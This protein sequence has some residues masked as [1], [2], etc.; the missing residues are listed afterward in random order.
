MAAMQSLTNRAAAPAVSVVIPLFNK[1]D[2]VGRAIRSVLNQSFTDFELIVVDDGSTDGGPEVVRAFADPRLRLIWQEN[3]GPGA[4][5]NWGIRESRAELIAFLDADDE[6]LPDF[7]SS[8]VA[9]LSKHPECVL[10]V[11]G[12]FMGAERQDWGQ[13]ARR[14]GIT[15]GPWRLP[16]QLRREEMKD[17]IGYFNSWAIVCRRWALDRYRG[18]YENRCTFGEDTYLWVQIALNHPVYRSLMPLVWYHS[19][20]S[21]LWLGSKNVLPAE[22]LL[23]DPAPLRDCCPPAYRPLLEDWLV[24]NAAYTVRRLNR[25]GNFEMARYIDKE[26]G[27]GERRPYTRV[28]L[29]LDLAQGHLFRLKPAAALLFGRGVRKIMRVGYRLFKT[30]PI[31]ANS[32]PGC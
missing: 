27:L 8:S 10:S 4:A 11:S 20:S 12:F 2:Y 15:E 1:V 16:P 22:P 24:D 29:L 13:I 26:F 3:E 30:G 32:T 28:K 25:S 21:E 18:F 14:A 19:E 9:W 17:F 7:L 6:W 31:P 23:T 5:R